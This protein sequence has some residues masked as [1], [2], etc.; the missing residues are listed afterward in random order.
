MSITAEVLQAACIVTLEGG[1][2]GSFSREELTVV[3][4]STFLLTFS[5]PFNQG[6]LQLNHSPDTFAVLGS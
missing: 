1:P 3:F 6:L 5:L 4:S 2:Q